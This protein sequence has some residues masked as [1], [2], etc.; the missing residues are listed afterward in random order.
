[1]LLVFLQ[2]LNPKM[3][4]KEA[5]KV[6]TSQYNLLVVLENSKCCPL[7]YYAINPS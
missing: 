2:I 5:Q 7:P 4:S 1:M 6:L 3:K